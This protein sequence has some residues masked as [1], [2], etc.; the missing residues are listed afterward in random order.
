MTLTLTLS[1]RP[2]RL[3]VKPVL[4]PFRAGLLEPVK[5]AGPYT[6]PLVSLT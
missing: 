1:T 3:V 2:C 6:R 5:E 4:R